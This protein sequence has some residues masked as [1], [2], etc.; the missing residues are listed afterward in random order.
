MEESYVP[1]S[2]YSC[3]AITLHQTNLIAF[4]I[5]AKTRSK[6]AN[7]SEKTNTATNTTKTTITSSGGTVGLNMPPNTVS[8]TKNKRFWSIFFAC[9]GLDYDASQIPAPW[10]GWMHYKTD[11]TP[12]EEYWRPKYPWMSDHSENF[13]GT[14]DQYVPYSTTRPKIE[15]W[16]P[17]PQKCDE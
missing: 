1:P 16:K 8:Y 2:N 17:P 5:L 14:P 7:S 11:L 15:P 12:C 9:Q 10:Y 3:R 6:L 13:T 4:K